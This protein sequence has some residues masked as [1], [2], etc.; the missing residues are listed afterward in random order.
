MIEYIQTALVGVL[1]WQI[2]I[3]LVLVLTGENEES[4]IFF[5]AFIPLGITALLGKIYRTVRLLHFRKRYVCIEFLTRHHEKGTFGLVGNCWYC[6]LSLVRRFETAHTA[7]K[8]IKS[9]TC[10]NARS[11][12]GKSEILTRKII[13]TRFSEWEKK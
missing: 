9:R 6:P 5:S 1:I 4:T 3:F 13:K 7:D 8:H 11:L 2:L 10:A 12:P